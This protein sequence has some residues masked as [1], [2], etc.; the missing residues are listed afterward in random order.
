[1]EESSRMIIKGKVA[2]VTGAS[3]GVG[4]ATALELGRRGCHVLLNFRKSEKE[5][6]AVAEEVRALGVTAK[7]HQADVSDDAACRKMAEFAASELGGI[8]I[9]VNNAGTTEFI[10]HADLEAVSIDVWQKIMDVN[11][12]GPFQCIRAALPHLKKSGNGEVVNVA[13]VAGLTTAG[14]S[15]PYGASKAALINLTLNLARS[16]GPELRINAVAPGFIDGQWLRDGLGE[17]FEEA[18]DAVGE[19]CITKRVSQPEDIADAIVGLIAG[20]DQVTGQTLVVDGGQ[21][22]A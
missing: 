19:S 8:D 14:S 7:T 15:I 21:S 2:I 11:V 22:I 3:R 9:L 6:E 4:R 16:L 10:P 17:D 5:A 20:S 12:L 13:S 1:M 18:R